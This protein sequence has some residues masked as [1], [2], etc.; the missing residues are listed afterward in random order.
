MFSGIISDLGTVRESG[1]GRLVI[2]TRYLM[3][4]VAIGA[5]I[6]CSGCCLTVIDK[7]ED[8][9]AA[10]VSAETLAVTTL[11]AWRP[12]TRVNLERPLR[13][14][15]EFG[16]HIVLGHVDGLAEV[17]ERRPDGAS[18][19]FAFEAPAALAGAI[20][21]KGS[22]ALDGVSLTVNEVAGRRFGVNVIP[23]TQE[24]TS[25]GTL[26]VG[27]AVNL[28]IDV[29]AR[30]VGRLLQSADLLAPRGHPL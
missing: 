20:A 30:Y 15:D 16:G 5:S 1:G 12:G 3:D 17:V 18:V 4:E 11:G 23:L 9:F 27:G 13:L 7:G 29:L 14:G 10:N 26:A 6:A 22:V 2:A 19:R 24:L 8:W 21:P 28:E 25:F